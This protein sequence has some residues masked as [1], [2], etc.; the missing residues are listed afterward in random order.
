MNYY[1]TLNTDYAN[2]KPYRYVDDNGNSYDATMSVMGPYGMTNLFTGPK[3]RILPVALTYVNAY[4]YK[5][6]Y[7]CGA[8]YNNIDTHFPSHTF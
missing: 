1:I 5:C 2:I 3:V 4:I 7:I 8:L 6:T